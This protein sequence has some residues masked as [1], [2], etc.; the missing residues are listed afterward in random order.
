M[1]ATKAFVLS[2]LMV[3]LPKYLFQRHPPGLNN[4]KDH[5]LFDGPLGAGTNRSF[6]S[7]HV[8]SVFSAAEVFRLSYDDW[9]VGAVAYSIAGT[10]GFQR[11]KSGS[12]WI[13]DVTTSAIWGAAIGHWIVKKGETR[14]SL[15]TGRAQNTD[16]QT[17]GLLLRF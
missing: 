5:L 2:R 9:W 3:Q 1:N 10:V 7:G 14:L 6:S 17:L 13:S 11:L 15:L 4:P 8:I 12:H 16:T